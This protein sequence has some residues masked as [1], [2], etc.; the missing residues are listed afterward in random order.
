MSDAQRSGPGG[1][2]PAGGG[3]QS[4]GEEP[5][6]EADVV[7]AGQE[8]ADQASREVAET[9][10]R[11]VE[12]EEAKAEQERKAAEQR[13]SELE[14]QKAE[15]DKRVSAGGPGLSAA[16]ITSPGVGLGSEPEAAAAA[17]KGAS[18]TPGGSSS[19]S[20]PAAG[21]A[22]DPFADLPFGDRPEIQAGIAFAAT[23]LIAKVLK[24]L[25]S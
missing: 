21:A 19:S 11:R 7:E 12:E 24:S 16:T 20:P 5:T 2:Y 22:N 14:Q 9:E 3:G 15:A 18:A 13:E 25:G 1:A 17:A 8:R 4:G 10:A 6:R 23:F